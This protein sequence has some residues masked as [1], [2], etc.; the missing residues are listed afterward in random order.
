[1]AR[2][3]KPDTPL[4]KM[5]EVRIDDKTTIF[6]KRGRDVEAAV[7]RYKH[8]LKNPDGHKKEE[9]RL[10]REGKFLMRK[11]KKHCNKCLKEK[12]QSSFSKLQAMADGYSGTCKDCME[13]Y[14]RYKER[15]KAIKE[16]EKAGIIENGLIPEKIVIDSKAPDLV[17]TQEKP[18]G[19]KVCSKCKEEKP[20]S[21]F[22]KHSK[23]KDGKQY[24]CKVCISGYSK[25]TYV[26]LS[27]ILK[28]HPE[29]K[30]CLDIKQKE[31]EELLVKVGDLKNDLDRYYRAINTLFSTTK[32]DN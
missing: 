24:W 1:M 2:R 13:K 9:D 8:H 32:K 12:S 21:N 17:L 25:E 3:I 7:E 26:S 11:G 15:E 31:L 16:Q 27:E 28:G 30:A 6:V 18:E 14:R 19:K 23:T 5:T 29:I 22:G 20:L 10:R 4:T